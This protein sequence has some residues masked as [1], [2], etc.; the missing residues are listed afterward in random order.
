MKLRMESS[1]QGARILV[2][3]HKM[4]DYIHIF[5]LINEETGAHR[6]SVFYHVTQLIKWTLD[7][8]PALADCRD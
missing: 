4:F 6:E 7:P 1:P 3:T 2:R 8:D 5:T